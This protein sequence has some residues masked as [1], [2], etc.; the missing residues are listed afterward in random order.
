MVV[1]Q[2]FHSFETTGVI[3]FA[4]QKQLQGLPE[5]SSTQVSISHGSFFIVALKGP[6]A[7]SQTERQSTLRKCDDLTKAT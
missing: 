5:T 3:S 6:T 2:H 1:E 4:S 7:H